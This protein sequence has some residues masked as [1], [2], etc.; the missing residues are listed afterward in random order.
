MILVT[1]G[2]Q[3]PFD[4]LIQQVDELAPSLDEPIVAQIGE[5]QY[6]PSHIEWHRFLSPLDFDALAHEA[7]LFISHAGIGTVLQAQKLGKPAILFP[8]KADLGEH[9]NDHQNATASALTGRLGIRIAYTQSDLAGYLRDGIEPPSSSLS[10]D[11]REALCG[12]IGDTIRSLAA[13]KK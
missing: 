9:R 10:T 8:R 1:V 4:R 12:A 3:L 13:G 6:V 11:A 5:G 7:R 2:T